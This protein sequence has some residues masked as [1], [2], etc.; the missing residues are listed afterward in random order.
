MAAEGGQKN[1]YSSRQ[2]TSTRNP[3]AATKPLNAKELARLSTEDR[4][5]AQWRASSGCPISDEAK[6]QFCIQCLGNTFN[7][8]DV[9]LWQLHHTAS[10]EGQSTIYLEF[11]FDGSPEEIKDQE[12]VFKKAFE[13]MI[14]TQLQEQRVNEFRKKL[15]TRRRG[16]RGGGGGED[17]GEGG[18][19][20]D[21]RSYLKKPVP[22]TELSIRSLREAGCMLRFLVCQ[23]SLSVSASEVLGQIAFQEHFPIDGVAQEPSKSTK[24]MPR[25]VYGLGACTVGM[26]LITITAWYQVVRQV[27]MSGG[28]AL[29]EAAALS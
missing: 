4:V 7:L 27:A 16:N 9:R 14:E 20:D 5:L 28:G 3:H 21:W 1:A 6:A 25:W 11:F 22:A 19:D 23:T 24:P 12:E 18:D 15:A 8:A 13:T 2:S 29:A 26:T 10:K 17:A